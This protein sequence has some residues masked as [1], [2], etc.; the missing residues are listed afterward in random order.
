MI[1]YLIGYVSERKTTL[2]EY[3]AQADSRPGYCM[4]KS[5]KNE[6]QRVWMNKKDFTKS[7]I[8]FQNLLML[9][10]LQIFSQKIWKY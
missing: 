4:T 5:S 10:H 6:F 3:L 8:K 9:M 7:S 2:D 1:I